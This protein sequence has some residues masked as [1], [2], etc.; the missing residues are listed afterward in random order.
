MVHR[1]PSQLGVGVT[2]AFF[3]HFV[4]VCMCVYAYMC[5]RIPSMLT[6]VMA[7]IFNRKAVMAILTHPVHSD[8]ALNYCT[9]TNETPMRLLVINMT[10]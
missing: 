7:Y 6:G 8:R 9:G 5:V 4:C 2:V 3:T 10:G 1:Y